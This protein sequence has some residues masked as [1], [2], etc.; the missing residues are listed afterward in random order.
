[1]HAALTPALVDRLCALRGWEPDA[2]RSLKLGYDEASGRIV[3]PIRDRDYRLVGLCRYQPNPDRRNGKPKLLAAGTRDLFPA[4]ETISAESVWLVE[5]EPDA[6]A[7]ASLGYPAVGVPGVKKWSD[8]WNERFARFDRVR[9]VFDCD[10]EGRAAAAQRQA[11]LHDVTD[12]D[13]IDLTKWV[14]GAGDHYDVGDLVL[15][16]GP[17]AATVLSQAGSSPVS[18]VSSL[19]RRRDRDVDPRRP[20]ERVLEELSR[21][22]CRV[23]GK[24]HQM[25]AQCPCHD[26]RVPS[27]SIAVGDDDRVLFSC[28]AGC[29]QD[30]VIAAM[31]LSWP[32]LFAS[33]S[34]MGLL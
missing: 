9:I 11:D 20:I 34:Q 8:E 16:Q 27:M 19:D 7:M 31:G 6:V 29:S 25:E 28:H 17:A 2:I 30:D 33:P 15:E 3:F 21:L 10:E 13:V 4:P 32:E 18:G 12:V 22:D 26:D 1:M 23:R 5:G 24:E 14:P